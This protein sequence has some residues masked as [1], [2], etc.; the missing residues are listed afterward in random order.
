MSIKST[1][2]SEWK[3]AWRRVRVGEKSRGLLEHWARLLMSRR[4]RGEKVQ[5][6]RLE[7]KVLLARSIRES[8]EVDELI[9]AASGGVFVPR[10]AI[11]IVEA[12][13]SADVAVDGVP[14]FRISPCSQEGKQ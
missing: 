14:I 10:S 6:I 4:Q 11:E 3:N 5:S 9:R 8:A 12:G 13:G 7:S 1:T 2:R